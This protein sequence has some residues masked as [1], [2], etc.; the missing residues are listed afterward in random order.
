MSMRIQCEIRNKNHWV[1]QIFNK[2]KHLRDY[3]KFNGEKIATLSCS[4][5]LTFTVAM[6]NMWCN[7]HNVLTQ[8]YCY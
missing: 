7:T 3:V 2:L 4:S 5:A 1:K 8:C 6:P